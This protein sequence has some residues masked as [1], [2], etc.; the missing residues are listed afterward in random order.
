[1]NESEYEEKDQSNIIPK[2]VVKMEHFYDLHDKFKKLTNC[3]MHSSSMKYESV[4]LGTKKDPK[5]V[6]LG[7]GCSP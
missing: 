6:N 4:N 5:N 1:M 3:K 7:L 2:S